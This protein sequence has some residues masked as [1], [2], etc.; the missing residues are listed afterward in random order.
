MQRASRLAY[1]VFG[2]LPPRL[3]QFLNRR[4]NDRFLVGVIG[5]VENARGEVLVLRHT[6]RPGFPWGLPSGWLRRRETVETA[7]QREIREETGY[8]V[9]FQRILKLES[10]ER[11]ARLDIWLSYALAGGEFRA[12]GEI[13]EARWC[14][15]TS[16][17]P[18][19]EAQHRLLNEHWRVP[20]TA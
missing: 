10:H 11:P 16:L 9:T 2:H 3:K 15:R 8:H 17:P 14:T 19:L 18:L 6:Y 12:S 5:V 1:S 4:L 20:R 7:L 13:S